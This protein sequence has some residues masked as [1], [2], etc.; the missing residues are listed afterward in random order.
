M[1][2]LVQLVTDLPSWWTGIVVLLALIITLYCHQKNRPKI[3]PYKDTSPATHQLHH[4]HPMVLIECHDK[5]QQ[6]KTKNN[7]NNVN[8]NSNSQHR[9]QVLNNGWFEK[10]KQKLRASNTM[11]KL[12][13]RYL[14]T[15]SQDN[16]AKMWYIMPDIVTTPKDNQSKKQCQHRKNQQQE[17]HY[18]L[19]LKQVFKGS[20]T[21]EVNCVLVDQSLKYLFT[22]SDDETISIWDTSTGTCIDKLV[23]T[24]KSIETILCMAWWHGNSNSDKYLLYSGTGSHINMRHVWHNNNI[25]NNNNNSILTQTLIGHTDTVRYLLVLEYSNTLISCDTGGTVIVWNLD[26]NISTIKHKYKAHNRVIFSMCMITDDN[27][28]NNNGVFVTAGFDQSIKFWNLNNTNCIYSINK[29]H[30]DS[31]NAMVY[32][33]KEHLLVT[34]SNDCTVRVWSIDVNSIMA[35][36]LHLC[37]TLVHD[38]QNPYAKCCS[39]LAFINGVTCNTGSGNT[40]TGGTLVLVG[41]VT[42]NVFIINILTGEIV[43][44]MS[45]AHD[46]A[47]WHMKPMS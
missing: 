27:N 19:K 41:D 17:F 36:N 42:G 24:T 39:S 2:F 45:K 11:G 16:T 46:M 21:C 20:D 30:D 4:Q 14:F 15:A 26:Q 32:N 13:P 44:E 22:G 12:P 5:K 31:I 37:A 9:V 47:I 28:N 10:F 29:A 18:F 8:N 33:N 35:D 3:Q 43:E 7:T 23:P 1:K 6:Y 38:I 34:A 40:G 25:L